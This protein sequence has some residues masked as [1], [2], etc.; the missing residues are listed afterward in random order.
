MESTGGHAVC[1]KCGYAAG[2]RPQSALYLTPGTILKEQYLVGR[3]L[4][5]GGFGI[6]YVGLDV[7]LNRKVA[8]KEY[9][10]GGVA[11]RGPGDTQVFAHSPTLTQEYTFGLERYL[12]EARLVASFDNHPN[13]VWVKNYFA[14][15]GTGYMVMEFLDGI[16]FET[17]LERQGGRVDWETVMR[18]MVPVM[19][20]L[21]EVHKVG[22][23]H[24][25]I[26]PDNICLLRTGMVKVIDF[27]AARNALGRASRNLSIIL[28]P[29]F[30]PPEQYQTRG[31]QGL[32]TDIY[33]VAG[34]MY[35]ALTGEVP[36]AAPDRQVRDELTPPSAMGF[37][38]PFSQEQALLA[39]LDLD[40][41][42]RF[43]ELGEFQAVLLG[44]ETWVAPS[45]LPKTAPVR[46]DVPVPRDEPPPTPSRI[47]PAPTPRKRGLPKWLV[48]AIAALAVILAGVVA[49]IAFSKKVEIRDFTAEP[50]S[51]RAGEEVQLRWSVD[52][53]ES[54]V[55]E[56][57]AGNQAHH[58][59]S[60][61][62]PT[63]N[64][65]YTLVA[66]PRW[67]TP[68]KQSIEIAVAALRSA[69]I[70]RFV[71]S[72]QSVKPGQSVLI[73]WTVA[74]AQEVLLDGQPVPSSGSVEKRLTAPAS[75]HLAA[76]GEDGG[77]RER[78]ISVDV[79]GQRSPPPVREQ[80]EIALFVFDP[81]SVQ[82]GGS[83]TLKWDV[84]GAAQVEIAGLGR[85]K[86]QGTYPV[87]PERN[88]LAKLTAR[89]ASGTTTTGTAT[90]SVI[91]HTVPVPG[92]VAP[93]ILSF[94]ANPPAVTAGQPVI[95][96]WST[97]GATLVEISP[98]PGRVESSGQITVTPR[99]ATRYMLRASNNQQI[100]HA[101]L[102]VQVNRSPPPPVP[103]GI[104]FA[105]IHDHDGPVNL[106]ANQRAW[107]FCNGVLGV[108]GGRLRFQSREAAYESFDVEANEVVEIKKNRL[109][110]RDYGAFHVKLSRGTNYNFVVR[111]G[112]PE[113]VANALQ[114]A[115]QK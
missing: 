51:I 79:E 30:A 77:V 73:S 104:S 42:R 2:Q 12:E 31:N 65:R 32:W 57:V 76:R 105:V 75:F 91:P 60:T 89:G 114:Q 85:V 20:A 111:Q 59:R 112:N 25:D 61:V 17:F 95:L 90:L 84:R 33:A 7:N 82:A 39:A 97:Q 83:S 92:P 99:G 34:T 21:R 70:E 6:T 37:N 26:S 62:R 55:I 53:A 8:I 101:E 98:E 96:S 102:T 86:P 3:V 54:V 108:S 41:E 50:R 11:I 15:N 106:G 93:R 78:A 87:R 24:R 100:S 22:I 28:K 63:R 19:D 64:T 109:G 66:T 103:E 29:G 56:G 1:P 46:R 48:G 5:H 68:V 27:G 47:L 13:I 16:T 9:F 23:L 74:D 18:V 94:Q 40:P 44:S 88:I 107:N 49:M 10:P 81:P 72:E 110:I 52:N 113:I 35:R 67:G 14:A 58:G 36:P 43:Q 69:S 4:G 115:L 71:A 80:V 45:P 38:I